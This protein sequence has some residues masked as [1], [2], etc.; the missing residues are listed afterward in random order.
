MKAPMQYDEIVTTHLCDGRF[1]IVADHRALR[2]LLN[3]PLN[4]QEAIERL[5]ESLST[6]IDSQLDA[7]FVV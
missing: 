6:W 2:E 5:C 1:E 3:D 7:E 4:G